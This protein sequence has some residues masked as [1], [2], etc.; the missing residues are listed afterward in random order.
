MGEAAKK[1]AI[2][3]I[4]CGIITAVI[5]GVIQLG[6]AHTGVKIKIKILILSAHILTSF[7]DLQPRFAGRYGDL[8]LGHACYVMAES[9]MN[10][11]ASDQESDPDLVTCS[12]E[13][14]LVT[15]SGWPLNRG[16]ILCISNTISGKNY[17]VTKS[18]CH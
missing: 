2:T 11:L 13:M 8:T 3:A 6:S 5:S 15:K 14:I 18:G 10:H 17:P 1:L 4:I 12:G 9:G 7:G 16:Q